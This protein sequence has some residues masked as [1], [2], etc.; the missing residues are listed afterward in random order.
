MNVQ[1]HILA[2]L[3]K[4]YA[5]NT[6][7]IGNRIHFLA[8][9][10]EHGK[11]LIFSPPDWEVSTAWNGPGGCMSL[12]PVSGRQAAFLAIQ[13]FFPIFKSEHAGIVYAEKT[14]SEPWRITRVLDLPFVHRIGVVQVESTPFLLAAT[15]CSGKSS[16]EDR[17]Q[18]GAVY[19]GSIPENPSD[20]WSLQPILEG[21]SKTMGCT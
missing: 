5:V 19:A 3:D 21:I 13:E 8:A 16:K 9:T 11:C 20:T 6:I 17:P 1:K 18:P 12:V 2:N 14:T 7:K 15:L 4:V 10:E